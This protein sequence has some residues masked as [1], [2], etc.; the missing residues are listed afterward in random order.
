MTSIRVLIVDDHP[1]VRKGLRIGLEIWD[2]LVV[3]GEADSGEQAVQLA[4]E[5]NPHVVLMDLDMPGMDGI[6]ATRIVREQMPGIRVLILTGS[7]EYDRIASAMAAGAV[8]YLLKTAR[9]EEIKTAVVE[10]MR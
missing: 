7:V 4:K 10:V 9:I 2:E 5:L 1:M 8:N 6:E 3:V